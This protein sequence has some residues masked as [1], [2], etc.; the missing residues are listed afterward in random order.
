[1]IRIKCEDPETQRLW[2]AALYALEYF[3]DASL[4]QKLIKGMKSHDQH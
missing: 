3:N 1:M 4:L 2:D